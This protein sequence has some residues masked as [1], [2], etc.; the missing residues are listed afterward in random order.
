MLQVAEVLPKAFGSD[1]YAASRMQVVRDLDAQRSELLRK[2]DETARQQGFALLR[3]PTGMGIA[4]AQK[5]EPL[6]QEQFA[7][8]S[9]SE[10]EAINQHGALLQEA[11]ERTMR[12]VRDVDEAAQER[13]SNLDREIAAA[14][15]K[16]F[17]DKLLPQYAAWPDVLTYL[18][19]I[20]THMAQNPHQLKVK[21]QRPP[22]S[23]E[24]QPEGDTGDE[25]A[26]VLQPWMRH[27]ADSFIDQYRL[28][29]IVDN[30]EL[31]GAP[32]IVETNPTYANLIGRVEM[33][34]EFGTLV[35]DYRHVKAGALHRANGG[36]LLLDARILL[37]QPF[38]WEAL[39]QALRNLRIR[40]EEGVPS[41]V[42]VA[43]T[44]TPEPIPL[45]V[46]VVLVG[47]PETYYTLYAYDEQFEKL[48]KV[49]ADFAVEMNWTGENE[50]HIAQFIRNRVE[51]EGLLHFDIS[52]V[53]KVIEYSARLVEDQRKLTTRFALVN[54]IVEEASFWAARAGR[55]L[56][57]PEDV[58][59]AIDERIYRSNQFEE[60]LREATIDGTIL[61]DVTGA[62]VGQVNGLAVLELG[63]YAFGRPT[64]ITAR[65][66]QG[67][68]GVINIERE[69]R[70]SGR[71]HDKGM[72]ILAGFVGGRYA[73]DKPLSLSASLAFEQSYEGID[74]DSASSTE[75][76][77]LLSSLADLP[78]KQ[79]I[80]VTGSVNQRGEV[81][82]IGGA[83]LKIEGFFDVC[84]AMVGGLTG[85]QGV[86]VPAANVP[87]LMLREDVVEAVAHGKFHIY[88]VRTVDEGIE[89]LTGVPAGE[90]GA[91]GAFPPDTVNGRVDGQ[92]RGL[93]EKL[94]Q[95]SQPA[96]NNDKEKKSETRPEE[97]HEPEK[98]PGLPGEPDKEPPQE[99]DLPVDQSAPVM[100]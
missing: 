97:E 50:V 60:R 40:M 61:V 37:R 79:G 29:V 90:R 84:R 71:I 80:A 93:A 26:D 68:A 57:I 66:Y 63:D 38:A 72:L 87:N 2:L 27:N 42:L 53:G 76:Y 46:K 1:Q 9:E 5:G 100:D 77:A 43:A 24:E 64:R 83:T 56:V 49:R 28:N 92:L 17:F 36:Y 96:K 74:G 44:L 55:S 48:F 91:D 14:T 21:D 6:S 13:L 20:Q 23:D 19:G 30:H 16:P 67:R 39:K 59:K 52:A 65:S 10:K 11:L 15:V 94:Q 73:Q 25:T 82:A 81:Q 31:Q 70:M 54:D 51:E 45:D 41:G 89:I 18:A 95:F 69:A 4:P 99:P 47:D 12:Q 78:I 98:A 75:L 34:A 58:A 32:V 88:P 22:V 7:A 62:V 3:T 35:S 85:E 33:R 86:I 8:L